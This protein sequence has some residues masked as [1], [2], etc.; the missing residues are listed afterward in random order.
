M[1]TFTNIKKVK[2]QKHCQITLQVSHPSSDILNKTAIFA[3]KVKEIILVW[4]IA[5]YADVGF[6]KEE[7]QG[8][9]THKH[10]RR[11]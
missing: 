7:Q 10:L 5:M 8:L 4:L 2:A 1:R 9:Q 3:G 6:M 11:G